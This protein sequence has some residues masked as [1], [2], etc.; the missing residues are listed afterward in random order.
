MNGGIVNAL[1]R[2][3]EAIDNKFANFADNE[4]PAGTITG[5]NAE[6]TLAHT[7]DP[8]GSLLVFLNGAFQTAGGEDYTLAGSTIT[9]VSAPLTN[10][11][12]R[13]FYRY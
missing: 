6:F 4:T 9:F 7:P 5:A 2:I 12:L 13:V 1:N 10:S 3:V 11:I 8:A